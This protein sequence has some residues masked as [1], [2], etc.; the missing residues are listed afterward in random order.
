MR[1]GLGTPRGLGNAG[2]LQQRNSG[3]SAA[4]GVESLLELQDFGDLLTDR[5]QRI[6]RRHRLLKDH[7]DV[8]ATDR[9]HFLLGNREQVGACAVSFKS[10]R[11]AAARVHR[12]SQQA[13]RS[14]RLAGT[15]LADQRQLLAARNRE[16]DSLD[17]LLAVESHPQAAHLKQ[18][19]AAAFAS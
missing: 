12:Q 9:T 7:R 15:R 10:G 1:E 11:A 16:V 6:Q 17:D 2:A 18:L 4:R 3:P 5:E 19:H 13:Q 8:L 14:D